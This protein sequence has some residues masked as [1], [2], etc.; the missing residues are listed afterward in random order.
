[1]RRTALLLAASMLLAACGSSS[2]APRSSLDAAAAQEAASEFTILTPDRRT[3]L[4]TWSS[5]DL[6]GYRW[7]TANLVGH[8]VVMNFWASWCGPCIEEWPELQAAAAAHPSVQFVGIN[9]MDTVAD[10]KAFL[11][12]HPTEYRQVEDGTAHLL[13]S[14]QDMPNTTLPTTVILDQY[15]R[16]AA[17]KVGPVKR[18][19]LRRVLGALPGLSRPA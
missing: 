14:L 7:S 12:Q 3:L 9:T 13:T 8:W 19:Q 17:W 5:T 15:H 1:M 11:H 2:P 18:E 4:P 6:D 10:A 16:V